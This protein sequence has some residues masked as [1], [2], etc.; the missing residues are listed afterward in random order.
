MWTMSEYQK[1]ARRT[2]IYP[3]AGNNLT[4]PTLGLCGEAGEFANKV[5][6]I[7]RDEGGKLTTS[8]K[9]ELIEELSDILWYVANLASELGVDLDTI[10]AAN[11]DKLSSREERGVLHG[12][13]DDR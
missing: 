1:T 12:S 7:Q 13:G 2:A 5:K 4:Y 8:R 6:K 3:D 11:I 9:L 10:A